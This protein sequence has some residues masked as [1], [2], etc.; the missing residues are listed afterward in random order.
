MDNEEG[1]HFSFTGKAG[2]LWRKFVGSLQGLMD[3]KSSF[4]LEGCETL[5]I[6]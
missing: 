6:T 4:Q 1:G 5:F 3:L 2:F